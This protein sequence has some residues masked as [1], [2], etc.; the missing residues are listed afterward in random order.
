[1]TSLHVMLSEE[2]E[3][4]LRRRASERGLPLEEYAR[5]V[6]EREAGGPEPGTAV[7]AAVAEWRAWAASHPRRDLS[8]D[9]SRDAIYQ[10]CGE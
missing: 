9:D 4:Q 1:M 6:L 5:G 2:T 10:G 3:Q 7:E 8:M